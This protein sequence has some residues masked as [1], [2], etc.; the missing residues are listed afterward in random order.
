MLSK[1]IY[2]VGGTV[3]AGGGLYIPRNADEELLNLCR[4]G[5]FAFVLSSRQVGKS[6]LMV[7]TSEQLIEEG[8]KPVIVDL[9]QIGVQ[10]TPES[11][12]L[13]FL[14][15]IA[16]ELE[17]EADIIGWWQSHS[18]IGVTQRLTQFLQEVLLTEVKEKIVIFIDEIDTTLSLDFTDDFFAAIRYMYNAR[19]NVPEYQRLTFVLLGVAT[20]SDLMSDPHR[21]PFN[22][23]QRVDLTDFTLDQ[24]MPLAEGL[25][26]EQNQA[27]QS[28]D[29]VLKWTSGHPYLTQRL[30]RAIAEQFKSE[31][32]EEDVDLAAANTFFG[33]M[34][35]ED[36]NLQFVR[37]MLTKW[38]PDRLKILTTYR[39]IRLG[40]RA[41][42][43]EEQSPIKNHLK[44]SG[45]VRSDNGT[46]K[47]RNAIYENVF[48]RKWLKSHWPTNW[49]STVP[50]SVKI[51]SVLSIILLI[52]SISLAVFAFNLAEQNR[53]IAESEQQA[54]NELQQALF[55]EQ[56]LRIQEQNARSAADEAQQKA[57]QEGEKAKQFAQA[58][59]IA[60][61]EVSTSR[62]LAQQ[63]EREAIA[64]RDS[65]EARRI[66][67]ERLRRIDIAR[68]LT[69]QAPIQQRLG[70]DELAVLL[71]RQAYLWSQGQLA[72]EVHNALRETL[73]SQKFAAGGPVV[74]RASDAVRSVAYSPD[75]SRLASGG[76][77]GK[78][79]FWQSKSNY[80]NQTIVDG[81]RGNIR[82]LAF[83][84]DAG[85]LVSAGDDHKI[86]L[87][88][89]QKTGSGPTVLD[90][91]TG[92]V[93]AAALSADGR[94]L[95]SGG[96]DSMLIVWK[97]ENRNG[98]PI[99]RLRL[100]ARIRSVACSRDGTLIFA[101][102]DDGA[103]QLF[104]NTTDKLSLKF[105][106]QLAT[107]VR[108]L[109]WSHDASKLAVGRSDGRI[110][111]YD[112]DRQAEK[113]LARTA[114]LGHIGPVNSLVF[115]ADGKKLVSGSSDKS[116]R[117]WDL[118]DPDRDP[119]TLQDH[120][121]WVWSVALSPESGTVISGSADKTIRV[122]NVSTQNLAEKVCASA[123]RN[124]SRAEW[125]EFIGEDLEYVRTCPNLPPGKG[126]QSKT[127]NSSH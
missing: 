22:I 26:L 98:R 72:N 28:L 120:Q 124:L 76:A 100:N 11:W 19:A 39:E 14:T 18:Q 106:S 93:W 37:D 115:S 5:T 38:A 2:T 96:A 6:S 108:S 30:C 125:D 58:E 15:T 114:L 52:T 32:C 55:R 110:E 105:G 33:K 36:N 43:D 87:W 78:L 101:G 104:E 40:K 65:A 9:T 89:V 21:T 25:G 94:S 59:Q 20:P 81:H 75:G 112:F 113:A 10:V 17:L 99:H 84:S 88:N 71:A 1:N 29:W 51:A 126:I 121:S 118:S 92:G 68:F 117:V 77:D 60:R 54:K 45:I 69:T 57:L 8:I 66:E 4:E 82:A 86:R 64:A 46:L 122:W 35:E 50:R 62:D 41:V 73:N 61:I 79:S 102:G 13:G 90:A 3:Q 119:V 123:G 63:R 127:S 42:P 107:A 48:E 7:G 116:I 12:Y 97:I 70:K 24:A 44:L 103:I 53:L 80:Q 34:S 31:L 49:L 16:D 23:G 56:D 83:S 95:V 85:T 74:L 109:A 47:V 67:V 91:H 27:R 111:L